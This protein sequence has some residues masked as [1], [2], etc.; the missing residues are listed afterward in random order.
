[1]KLR[2]HHLLCTQFYK[3]NGYSDE[4]VKH[5]DYITDILR[6][7]ENTTVDVI[8]STD[9]I[10]IK[11]PHMLDVNLCRTNEKVTILDSKIIKYFDIKEEIYN[12]KDITK[13]IIDSID[14]DI[15]V[16]ICGDCNWYGLC[17]C[18]NLILK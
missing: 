9:D 5:M 4:F 2:P 7:K 6:N 16:D 1:M 12:Y 14:N 17:D 13:F 10:C 15:L 8:F 11:C 3:G 18:K